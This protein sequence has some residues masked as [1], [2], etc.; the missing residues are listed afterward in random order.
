MY[1]CLYRFGFIVI[2]D[3]LGNATYIDH[4]V[5]SL[6][7]STRNF[8]LVWIDYFLFSDLPYEILCRKVGRN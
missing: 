2:D 8:L 4:V 7:L 1:T 3:E 5:V 6:A